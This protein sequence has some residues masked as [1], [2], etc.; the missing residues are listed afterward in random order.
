MKYSILFLAFIISTT[1][2]CAQETSRIEEKVDSQKLK[3][4]L[5]AQ[6]DTIYKEDQEK[7]LE[8]EKVLKKFGWDSPEMKALW[9]VISEKDSINLIKVKKIIDEHGWLGADVIGPRGNQT[10]FLVIQHADLATQ[11]KYLPVVREAVKNGK[12]E[13]SAL[14]LLEDRVALRQGKKQVYGSQIGMDNET[15]TYYVSPLEDPENVDKRRA[16]VGLEPLAKYLRHW[17]IKWN[18]EQYKKD[19]PRIEAKEK[20]S[21]KD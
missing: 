5:V 11:E 16:A 2:T 20:V 17:K 3:K 4:R 18:V 7:R 19:L 21:G 14:A 15:K 12:A 8:V 9:K 10:L 13:A 1:V 6:L